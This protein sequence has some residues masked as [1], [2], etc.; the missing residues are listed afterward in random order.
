MY[1]ISKTANLYF[2]FIICLQMIPS[3]SISG[4]Q[5]TNLPPLLAVIAISMTKDFIEDKRR[6]KS[7]AKENDAPTEALRSGNFRPAMWKDLK[8]GDVVKIKKG[9]YFPADLVLL[10]SSE[11]KSI[12]FVETKGL[13]GESNLKN[14]QAPVLISQLDPNNLAELANFRVT[15]K[16]PSD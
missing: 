4:G 5:P 7:D 14:K 2:V 10:Q 9:E 3:I 8:V 16:A 6:R 1:Q 11:Y 12:C 15:C 13:D